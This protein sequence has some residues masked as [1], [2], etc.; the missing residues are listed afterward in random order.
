MISLKE[1]EIIEKQLGREPR[2]ILEVPVECQF[3]FPV[4][5][6]TKPLIGKSDERQIFP[7]LY[8]LTCPYRVEQI[9]KI[10]SEGFIS[11]LEDRLRKDRNMKR[12]YIE[13]QKSYKEERNRL[14]SESDRN[15]L[16]RQSMEESLDKGIGGIED[17][18]HVKCLHMHLA[19]HLVDRNVVGSILEKEFDIGD[20]PSD[21]VRCREFKN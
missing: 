14:L 6:K 7:T 19:H 8:W 3:G 9:S 21:K 11:A 20:C 5:V 1:K 15:F 13:Q 17:F 12:S 18:S 2:G 16:K 4:V 10:E